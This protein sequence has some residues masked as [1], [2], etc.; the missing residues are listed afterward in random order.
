MAVRLKYPYNIF[1]ETGVTA[2]NAGV[3]W[4]GTSPL[5][6]QISLGNDIR[7]T[8]N[9][10][11]NAV[12]SSGYD[13]S[14]YTLLSDRWTTN[15]SAGSIVTTGNITIGGNA[16]ISGIV[17]AEKFE[18]ELTS[19]TVIYKSGST[20]FGDS[21]DDTHYFTGSLNQT[22]SF[23]LN[24]YSVKEISN[25]TT[26]TDNSQTALATES[27]SR[28]YTDV[29]VGTT[30]SATSMDLYLRNN[31]MK[32]ST[33]ISNNTASFSAFS[34]SSGLTPEETTPTNEADYL[35]FNNGQI[36]E[37]DS[38]TIEQSGSTFLLIVDPSG[39][40]YNL[41]SDD[42]IKAWGKFNA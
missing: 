32:S 23:E 10:Q 35:F 28:A 17:T 9:V 16:T 7:I 21:L 36:M 14:G 34:A 6:Q 8:G 2:S 18:A 42:E 38:L 4:D 12:T 25:D 37:H 22:G 30:E 31:F 33:S 1:G 3:P 41:E 13:L 27:S 29:E 24:G 11:F 20:Q 26:L 19:S 15:F 39:I 40:G 5:T